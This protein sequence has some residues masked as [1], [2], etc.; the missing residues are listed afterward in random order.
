MCF[1]ASIYLLESVTWILIQILYCGQQGER[2]DYSWSEVLYKLYREVFQFKICP[3]S[4]D[5]C[6]V[7]TIM[8]GMWPRIS[9]KGRGVEHKV[10]ATWRHD[11][12]ISFLQDADAAFLAACWEVGS[13]EEAVILRRPRNNIGLF[14]KHIVSVIQVYTYCIKCNFNS[15]CCRKSVY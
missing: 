2:A 12:T 8:H 10:L 15:P 13:R 4:W 7:R 11:C 6:F 14:R 3:H 5:F 1:L 9:R